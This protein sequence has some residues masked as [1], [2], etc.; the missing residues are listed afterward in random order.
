MYAYCVFCYV[1]KSKTTA[2]LSENSVLC[3][4]R[5]YTLTLSCH[6]ST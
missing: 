2:K 6:H 5:A 1:K 4:V 3:E